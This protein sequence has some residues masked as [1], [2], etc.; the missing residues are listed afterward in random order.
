MASTTVPSSKSTVGLH[1]CGKISGWKIQ[2]RRDGLNAERLFRERIF[3][4][5]GYRFAAGRFLS[6]SETIAFSCFIMRTGRV[7]RWETFSFDGL[8]SSVFYRLEGNDGW[9]RRK[10]S[11]CLRERKY[12]LWLTVTLIACIY[13][14]A[15][16]TGIN[17][18]IHFLTFRMT[19]ERL[20]IILVWVKLL[21]IWL[22]KSGVW[23]RVFQLVKVSPS[24]LT[25]N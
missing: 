9:T 3:L 2:G 1:P 6:E 14:K 25:V 13:H 4:R 5:A 24:N 21:R 16:K 11:V 12:K 17:T 8:F 7:F 19:I 10:N 18:Y 22:L 23:S 15:S 20:R